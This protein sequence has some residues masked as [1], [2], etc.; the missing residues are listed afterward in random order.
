MTN[1]RF[2]PTALT[3]AR[4][5]EVTVHRQPVVRPDRSVH[6]YAVHVGVRAPL[7]KA[8]LGD[9]LDELVHDRYRELDLAALVHQD[10]AF[11]RATTGMLLGTAAVPAVPGGLVLEV[12]RAFADRSDAAAHLERLRGQG[13][14]L[15][16]TGYLPGVSTDRLLPL[17]DFAK[18]DLGRGREQAQLTIDRAHELGTPVLA[19]RVLRTAAVTFCTEAGVA[20]LQGPLF[21]RDAPTLPRT[22]TAG[23][24]QCLELMQ[25]LSVDQVDLDRVIRVVGADP[26]LAMQVLRQVN[27]SAVAARRRIDSVR[28]AVTMLGPQPLSALAAASMIDARGHSSADLWFVL[29][30]ALACRTITRSDAGYTVGL[31]SAVAS[32]LAADP[33]ELVARAGVSPDVGDAV[34]H[35]RGPYGPALAAVLAHE[36]NDFSGVESTGLAPYSVANAYLTA[37]GAGLA[38]TTS[39][40][41]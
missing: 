10:V 16:L 26:E 5:I 9:E 37:L 28:Q 36:E 4:S 12:P 38:M 22:F 20:L 30:R 29:T 34:L 40:G 2:K 31:L 11:I 15:A 19:E 7:A 14:G 24:I 6:G 25:L 35:R 1:A 41:G 33:A 23:Q 21:P 17:V 13:V 32:Q 27:S 39:L 18:V 8:H 3:T